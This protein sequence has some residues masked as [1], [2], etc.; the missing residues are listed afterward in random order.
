MQQLWIVLPLAFIIL[1]AS[2]Y[3][4][5]G[6]I[7]RLI[8]AEHFQVILLFAVTL[9]V[10]ALLGLVLYFNQNL[11]FYLIW[12]IIGLAILLFF[13]FVFTKLRQE[14]LKQEDKASK[15]VKSSPKKKS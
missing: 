5:K 2:L 3:F 4:Y 10:Y 7:L 9:F 8:G 15:T 13:F 11:T 1:A 12:L 6:T 14:Q